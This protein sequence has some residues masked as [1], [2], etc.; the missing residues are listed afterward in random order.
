MNLKLKSR[1]H[2]LRETIRHHD[3]LYY[4]Q[5]APDIPDAEYD[6]LLRE[7][8]ELERAHPDLITPDSPT[9]RVGGKPLENF[10]QVQHRLPMLSLDNAFSDEEFL[11][12]DR[13]VRERLEV[14]SVD[15]VAEPKLDGLAISLLYEAGVLVR[16][17]TRGDGSTGEDVTVNIRTIP[18]IPL[19]LLGCNLP[20]IIEIR[21]EVYISHEGFL[22]LNRQALEQDQ[23][24]FANPRNAAAGSLRQLDPRITATR[25]LEMYCYGVGYVEGDMADRHSERLDQLRAWGMRVYPGIKRLNGQQACLDHYQWMTGQREQL[26]FD[27]DGVVYKV[28]RLD[29]QQEM[30]FVARAPRWAIARK[31]PAQEAIT[32]VLAIDVQVGRTGAITPVARLEPVFVGGVTVTNAT[33]HNEDEIRRKDVRV[34]DTVIVRRA[35]DVIPEVVSVVLGQRPLDDTQAFVMPTHCPVCGS[36]VLRAEGEAVMRCSGGLFCGAQRKEAIKHFAARRAMDV[37]GLGDKI[38]EQLVDKGL[39]KTVA[40]LYQLRIEDVAELDRMAEKSAQNLLDALEKSKQTSLPRFLFALGIR[41]VGE[42][43][44]RILAQHY[45]RLEAL[46]E[47][48]E[49]KLQVI[50]GIGP[51]MAQHIAGFFHQPHNLEVIQQLQEAGVQW[52]DEEVMIEQPLKGKIFVLTGTLEHIKRNEAKDQLL[53]KGAKVSAS[54]SKKTDYVVAGTDPGSKYTKAQELGV[55]IL[56]EDELMGMLD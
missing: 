10:S 30:G 4:M 20:N 8:Q 11:D 49:E 15:Y 54:V 35:G 16:A 13:R 23:K 3:N 1:L 42:T 47:S 56:T 55:S 14:E 52:P 43:S 27:I 38:V 36:E 39:I 37:D 45:G 6:R 12:F 26:P 50:D 40:D 5:D 28:D 17:A 18:S 46:M 51:V 24:P 2:N 19:S 25:P 22:R 31:F 21:G 41:E 29:Q 34:G 53:A 33:L 48:T 32:T 44:A 7:L 9:Q